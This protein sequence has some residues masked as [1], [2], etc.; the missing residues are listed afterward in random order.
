[1]NVVR[2]FK[3]YFL[4]Y[5][6]VHRKQKYIHR[7]ITLVIPHSLQMLF[8][9]IVSSSGNQVKR[10]DVVGGGIQHSAALKTMQL[11][12]QN[13]NWEMYSN[14]ADSIR[15]FPQVIKQKVDASLNGFLNI[16]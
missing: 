5:T 9:K 13:K 2:F 7:V 10:V 15:H 4:K 6:R 12:D 3:G 1:M 16:Q 8:S 14:W 11:D